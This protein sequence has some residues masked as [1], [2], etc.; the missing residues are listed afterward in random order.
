VLLG[1]AEADAV[2]LLP[3]VTPEG[4]TMDGAFGLMLA[5]LWPLIVF[6]VP[7]PIAFYWSFKH[8]QIP[9]PP[10]VEQQAR[11]VSNILAFLELALLAAI[12]WFFLRRSEEGVHF[13]LLATR[14]S[15]PT[16]YIGILAGMVW[17]ALTAVAI[18][19]A[20]LTSGSLQKN[21]LVR[22]PL[23]F[24]I[25]YGISGAVAEELWRVVC[26]LMLAPFGKVL[27]V[28]VT[29]FAFGL[30]HATSRARFLWI[31]VAGIYLAL[32]FLS[33]GS[34]VAIFICHVV[35][36]MATLALV[37]LRFSAMTRN[38]R[39]GRNPRADTLV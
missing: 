23:I 38:Q 4:D 6:G 1:G 19:C 28:S 5:A 3:K 31:S 7:N 22:Q 33:T 17:A 14:P 12:S 24:S 37:R 16:I 15:F 18:V 29:S 26:L 32:I 39:G 9:Q 27:A 10:Y 8:R 36:N 20:R 2:S 34:F 25:P 30:A 11:I 13:R 35:M 21:E